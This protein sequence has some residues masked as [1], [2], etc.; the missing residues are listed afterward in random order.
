MPPLLRSGTPTMPMIIDKGW[1]LQQ[2]VVYEGPFKVSRLETVVNAV[3]QIGRRMLIFFELLNGYTSKGFWVQVAVGRNYVVPWTRGIFF[4]KV[5]VFN[6]HAKSINGDDGAD[7][8]FNGP[9]F[10]MDDI[11]LSM[12][13]RD[14]KAYTKAVDLDTHAAAVYST[15]AAGTYFVGDYSKEHST[16]GTGF[17]FTGLMDEAYCLSTPS[18][19]FESPVRY[20]TYGLQF[21]AHMREDY[22][23]VTV[24]WNAWHTDANLNAIIRD[25]VELPM[26][27]PII[28]NTFSFMGSDIAITRFSG[29]IVIGSGP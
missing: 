24:E 4:M 19:I 7:I 21:A 5:E 27:K 28:N 15:P 2:C 23:P 9:V 16:K 29:G 12:H 17:R 3:P 13:L 10:D 1:D 20:K 8:P 26:A 18:R 25:G 14:G 6:R 11:R 22:L